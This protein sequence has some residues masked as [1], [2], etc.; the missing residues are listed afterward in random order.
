ML[1]VKL[2]ARLERVIAHTDEVERALG[3]IAFGI[4]QKARSNLARHRKTGTH[5]ITQTKGKVDHFVNLVGEAALSVENGHFTDP[6]A[7]GEFRFIRGL[8][9]VKDAIR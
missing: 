3:D 2:Y 6:V 1:N 9:I 8:N 4:T 5:K 7:T